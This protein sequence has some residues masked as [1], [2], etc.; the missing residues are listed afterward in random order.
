[1]QWFY[2]TH[3]FKRALWQVPAILVLSVILGLVSN[4]VRKQHLPTIGDWSTESRLTTDSGDT[5]AIPFLEAVKAFN[6]KTAIFIDARGVDLFKEGHIK[7][8]RNLPW[9]DVDDYFMDLAKD[10]QP[11]DR[12]ITYCDGES[13]NLSHDLALFL[14]DMGFTNVKVL[15]NGWT[16]WIENNLPIE[17]HK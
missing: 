4:A 10:I 11:T 3:Q 17:K 9:H 7:G 8:A 1:M 2:P 6:Q 15:V 5:L 13:C 12:I 14:V 16:V